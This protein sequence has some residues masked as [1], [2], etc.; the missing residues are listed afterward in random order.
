MKMIL[1]GIAL[2]LA[3]GLTSGGFA[4]DCEICHIQNDQY[5][6]ALDVDLQAGEDAYLVVWQD[7]ETAD[8]EVVVFTHSLAPQAP[9]Q[10]SFSAVFKV[11]KKGSGAVIYRDTTTSPVYP[12]GSVVY[13]SG[14]KGSG[15]IIWR[16]VSLPDDDDCIEHR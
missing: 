7:T 2:T 15:A 8:L 11:K 12:A 1:K 10:V 6:I 13:K 14:K 5:S 4:Q 16:D 9:H 3:F